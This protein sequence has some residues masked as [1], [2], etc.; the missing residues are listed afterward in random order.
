MP[1]VTYRVQQNWGVGWFNSYRNPHRIESNA[2]QAARKVFEDRQAKRG[3]SVRVVASDG[4]RIWHR[5][6]LIVE[7]YNPRRASSWEA[8]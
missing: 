4:R 3:F 2:I 1:S 5:G 7:R 6:P 8:A